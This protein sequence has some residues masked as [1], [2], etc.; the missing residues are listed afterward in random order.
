MAEANDTEKADD[1]AMRDDNAM[2]MTDD[3]RAK[4]VQ[5]SNIKYVTS[6]APERLDG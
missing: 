4:P 5:K 3:A 6:Q 1:R 2:A